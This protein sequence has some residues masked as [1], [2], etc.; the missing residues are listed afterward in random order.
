MVGAGDFLQEPLDVDDAEVVGAEG[1]DPDHAEVGV[2]HHHRVGRAPLV[3]GEQPGVHEVD[4][5]LERRIEAELPRL[6]PGEHRNVVGG[7]RVLARAEGVAELA[8]VDELR[9]LRFADDQLR[10]VL[11]RLVVV[12]KAVRQRVAGVIGPLDDLDQ[13]ALEEVD[14]AHGGILRRR[15]LAVRGFAVRRQSRLEPAGLKALQPA[16]RGSSTQTLRTAS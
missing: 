4:V 14:D 13:L 12:G 1:A 8:D 7:Q 11:D 5:G 9:M 6:Q 10:A 16:G 15:G 2:A 3:A